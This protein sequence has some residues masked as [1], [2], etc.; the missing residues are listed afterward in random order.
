MIFHFNS[1]LSSTIHS[2]FI[3]DCTSNTTEWYTIYSDVHIVSI[4]ATE[5]GV[6]FYFQFRMSYIMSFKENAF[7]IYNISSKQAMAF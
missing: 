2:R 7:F 3:Y 5:M 6:G 1:S 4:I